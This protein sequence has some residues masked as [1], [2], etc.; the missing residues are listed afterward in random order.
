MA[1]VLSASKVAACA[2]D[3]IIIVGGLIT[4]LNWKGL[5]RRLHDYTSRGQDGGW[6][7]ERGFPYFRIL[8]GGTAIAFG[9]VLFGVAV[10]SIVHPY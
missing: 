7:A 3:A 1:T 2:A 4:V 8:L 5:G 10:Y 6:Y 9:A